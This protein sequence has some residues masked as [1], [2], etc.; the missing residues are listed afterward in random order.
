MKTGFKAER[1]I[2]HGPT[3]APGRSQN[4][5]NQLTDLNPLKNSHGHANQKRRQKI[6]V[7]KSIQSENRLIWPLPNK[8]HEMMY[9]RSTK[10]RIRGGG[11]C[12][13]CQARLA[14]WRN[15][16]T[17]A[18]GDERRDRRPPEPSCCCPRRGEFKVCAMIPTSPLWV[19]AMHPKTP[20]TGSLAR[21]LLARASSLVAERETQVGW[22]IDKRRPVA[23]PHLVARKRP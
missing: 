9:A 4:F 15:C 16:R 19:C 5:I 17:P 14:P 2:H 1:T 18:G 13:P 8:I 11:T 23:G 7:G 20:E 21:E 6:P 22:K 10:L 3:L 12:R